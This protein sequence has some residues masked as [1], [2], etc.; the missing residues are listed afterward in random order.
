MRSL[1]EKRDREIDYLLK[2]IGQQNSTS[3]VLNP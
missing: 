2:S 1:V 3:R